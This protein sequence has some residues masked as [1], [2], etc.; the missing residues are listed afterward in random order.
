MVEGYFKHAQDEKNFVKF[1]DINVKIEV[2]L[3]IQGNGST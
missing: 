3:Q 1:K 2:W